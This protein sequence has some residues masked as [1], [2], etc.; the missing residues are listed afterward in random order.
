MKSNPNSSPYYNKKYFNWQKG[1]GG[2][3]FGAWAE[4]YKFNKSINK[5][6][7]VIDFGCGGGYVLNALSCKNRIGIEPNLGAIET[8][9]QFNIRHFKSPVEALA[10]L[11][12]DIADV[13]ISNHA[14]EHTLNPLDEIIELKKLLKPGGIAHFIVPCESVNMS[15]NPLNVDHHLYTWSPMNLG[16]LFSEAGYVVESCNPIFHKWPP[17]YQS[18]SKLGWPIFNLICKIYGRISTS[19][20]QV[21]I[22]AKKP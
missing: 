3:S 7:T 5:H 8:L 12:G 14:L 18:I 21:E 22:I 20:T 6:S 1:E 11:G 9:S 13:I 2:G 17:F 16:N 19:S 15:Y 4:P 10:T